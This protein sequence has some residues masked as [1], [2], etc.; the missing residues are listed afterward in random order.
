MSNE[1]FGPI[2]Y[3]EL[4]RGGA[5][6]WASGISYAAGDVRLSLV[7]FRAYVRTTAGGGVLD[8]AADPT[9]WRS[10][11]W[12]IKSVQRGTTTSSSPGASNPVIVT[13]SAVDPKKAFLNLLS[14]S[15]TSYGGVERVEL[16]SAT[17]L[18][19]SVYVSTDINNYPATCSWE[20][21]EWF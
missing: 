3:A 18:R 14:R 20:V 17:Q 21:I 15:S 13:I 5:P 6:L 2:N 10:P 19:I 12:G 9:N 4:R 11:S 7:D 1:A 8:P 16:I